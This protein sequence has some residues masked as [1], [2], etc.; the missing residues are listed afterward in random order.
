MLLSKIHF[1][2]VSEARV[3]Y[4]G[5]ITIPPEAA[6]AAGFLPG[7]R[8]LVANTRNGERFVTYVM[9]GAEPGR[10]GLN[11]AAAKLGVPGDRV[12]VLSFAWMDEEEARSHRP[13]RVFMD[14]SNRIKRIEGPEPRHGYAVEGQD[15]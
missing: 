10:F 13:R 15:P 2:V 8:V 1:A 12:I 3:D 6:E 7:E 5:S 11:G 4:E 9:I 14:E